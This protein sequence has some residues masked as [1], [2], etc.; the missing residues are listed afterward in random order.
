MIAK[1][2]IVTLVLALTL[3]RSGTVGPNSELLYK[4]AT[5]IGAVVAVGLRL[6]V[7]LIIIMAVTY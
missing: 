3:W 4:S 7:P 5:V 6:I 1:G 2:I